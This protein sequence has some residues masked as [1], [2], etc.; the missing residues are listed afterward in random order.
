MQ[1]DLEVI[2]RR[3]RRVNQQFHQTARTAYEFTRKEYADPKYEAFRDSEAGRQ[4]KAQKLAECQYRCPECNK[5]INDYNSNIDHKH[6]RRYYPWL[7]WNLDNLWVICKDCNTNKS[8]QPW[9]DYLQAVRQNR[10]QAAVNRILR[11][12]PPANPTDTAV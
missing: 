8:D 9:D 12:A 1:D 3:I 2:L 4:W 10:G 6:P 5:S 11:Y 7:A